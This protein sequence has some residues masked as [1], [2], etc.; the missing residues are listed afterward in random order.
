M[1]LSYFT[2]RRLVAPLKRLTLAT[3]RIGQGHLE[4][5]VAIYAKGEV[6]QLVIAFNA[7]VDI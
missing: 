4:E 2:S 7:M 3:N 6:G 1:I 5:R